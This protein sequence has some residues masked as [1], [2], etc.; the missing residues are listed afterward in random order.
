MKNLLL[1]IVGFLLLVALFGD[2]GLEVSPTVAPDFSPQFDFSPNVSYA[3]QTTTVEQQTNI[4]TNVEH[5]TVI[6]QPVVQGGYGWSGETG[7]SAT[8]VDPPYREC[9]PLPG[10]TIYEG[11]DGRGGCKV[12]D[13]Q[14]NRFFINPAGSR[15]PLA[16]DGGAVQA[17]VEQNRANG[18]ANGAALQPASSPSLEQMQAAYLRNGGSLPLTWSWFGEER[19]RRFL[20]DRPETWR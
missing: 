3:P 13:E 18:G 6:V 8:T 19:K 7:L 1:I 5:Q 15:W 4:D 17:W 2:G 10:E 14:G 12:I 16:N 11:P 20:A 9:D